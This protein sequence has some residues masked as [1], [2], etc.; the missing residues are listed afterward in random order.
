MYSNE[1]TKSKKTA[2]KERSV[3]DK[4]QKAFYPDM[5]GILSNLKQEEEGLQNLLTVIVT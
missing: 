5:Q 2:L 1:L 3:A 4:D